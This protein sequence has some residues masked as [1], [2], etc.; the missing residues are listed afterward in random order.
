MTIDG[1]N[2][3]PCIRRRRVRYADGR[4]V[5]RDV[6]SECDAAG[7]CIR[8]GR[9][10]DRVAFRE[11]T[12]IGTA[13][14]VPADIGE[15]KV[16]AERPMNPARICRDRRQCSAIDRGWLERLVGRRG[17]PRLRAIS[18]EST[19]RRRSD[20][21]RPLRGTFRIHEAR[22]STVRHRSTCEAAERKRI[23]DGGHDGFNETGFSLWSR[24]CN[25]RPSLDHTLKQVSH[26]FVE[27]SS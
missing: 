27:R 15:R 20:L 3:E 2:P 26:S 1:A 16:D 21:D 7:G 25:Q 5:D 19:N 23:V 6:T 9:V 13:Q 12:S 8:R 4:V 18:S 17:T 22:R 24:D 14:F 10:T 11:T